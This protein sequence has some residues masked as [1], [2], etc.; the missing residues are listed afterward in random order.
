M[1]KI[2]FPSTMKPMFSGHETFPLRQ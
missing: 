2:N 1:N